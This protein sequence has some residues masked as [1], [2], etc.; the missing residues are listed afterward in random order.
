MSKLAITLL[1]KDYDH[2][3]PLACGDIQA[4]GLDLTLLRDTPGALDRTLDDPSI[5][6][7]EMSFSKYLIRLASGDTSYVG[8]PIF[9][10]RSF[11]A[12]NFYVRRG[13]SL[14]S[15]PEL[16]GKRVGTNAWPDTGNMWS[17][18]LLRE[19]GVQIESIQWTVGPVN[20]GNAPRPP[21]PLP[22]HAQLSPPGR[23][24]REMLLD[25]ELDALMCPLPPA[26]FRPNEGPI[27]RLI[28]D[29]RRA[30]Q[31]YYRRT[32][33]NPAGHIVTLRR[34]VFERAPWVAR[35]LYEVLDRSQ[36][37]WQQRR[38]RLNDTTPWL[39]DDIEQATALFGQDWR[40]NGVEANRRAIEVLCEEELAQGMIDKPLDP[41]SV[42]ADFE[43]VMRRG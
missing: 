23:G 40:P 19:Q 33:V 25:G 42:F 27:A 22:A 37:L 2:L 21:D 38:R 15:L 6:A 17:R 32:G 41:A 29:F 10:S 20:D 4:E 9:P 34:P 31:E 1:L 35:S 7:G 28:P 13:S 14:R 16:A 8:I 26:G 36:T 43:A 39:L 5:D 11:K 18:A 12:R 24:L 30:E 3:S